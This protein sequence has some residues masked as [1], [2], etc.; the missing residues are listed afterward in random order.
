MTSTCCGDKNSL[1]SK[2]L[3]HSICNE[4]WLILVH[5]TSPSTYRYTLKAVTRDRTDHY[6]NILAV[7]FDWLF[8]YSFQLRFAFQP[9]FHNWFF[10]LQFHSST[11]WIFFSQHH[12]HSVH[13]CELLL[14]TSRPIHSAVCLSD[15]W[16][17]LWAL[18]IWLNWSRYHLKCS[19]DLSSRNQMGCTWM[20][21]GK[22]A[23]W[24]KMAAM[25][26]LLPLL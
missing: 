14:Q 7:K 13:R 23:E 5:Y 19:L 16:S 25:R 26:L 3:L 6:S 20:L 12:M 11:D 21:R 17:R 18:Q 9:R 10:Q 8:M 1:V 4:H 15:F 2:W 24:S 22:S